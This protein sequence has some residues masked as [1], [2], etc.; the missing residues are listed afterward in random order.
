MLTHRMMAGSA[1]IFG[2]FPDKLDGVDFFD[3]T[4]A[5]GMIVFKTAGTYSITPSE[6]GNVEVL[7][8]GGGGGGDAS[9]SGAGA[10]GMRYNGSLAVSTVATGIIVGAGGTAIASYPTNGDN[11]DDSSFG[12]LEATGGGGAGYGAS[13]SIIISGSGQ[14][15]GSGGGAGKQTGSAGQGEKGLGNVPATDPVQGYDGSKPAVKSNPGAG[16]GAGGAASNTT[17]GIGAEY[18]GFIYAYGGNALSNTG[19][20][21]NSGNG[22]N[23]GTLGSSGIVIVRWGGYSSNYNPTTDAVT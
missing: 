20:V 2:A 22:G 5:K 10:G 21:N 15:G 7:V 9:G 8:V 11:G 17:G 3:G 4:P 23:A 18:F 16:G 1:G 14:N 12:D 13:S 6:A 19:V